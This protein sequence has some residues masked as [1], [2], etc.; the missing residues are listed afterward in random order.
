MMMLRFYCEYIEETKYNS[1][2]RHWITCTIYTTKNNYHDGSL[3]G[4]NYEYCTTYNN[5]KYNTTCYK[6][7][8]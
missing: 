3:Y 5:K 2:R 4:I 7:H 8:Q 1:R 6:E